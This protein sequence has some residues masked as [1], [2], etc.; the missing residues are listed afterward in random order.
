[1]TVEERSWMNQLCALL[2]D[3]KDPNRFLE[4]IRELNSLLES[5]RQGNWI[6]LKPR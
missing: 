5:K 2:A 1:M 4:L 3:E 6:E